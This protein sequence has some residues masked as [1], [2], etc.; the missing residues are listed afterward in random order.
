M[1]FSITIIQSYIQKLLS[2]S[3]LYIHSDV[4]GIQTPFGAYMSRIF[5]KT[6]SIDTMD[7]PDIFQ[8]CASDFPIKNKEHDDSKAQLGAGA[9]QIRPVIRFPSADC[10][11]FKSLEFCFFF[12]N[13]VHNTRQFLG[14]DI[15][16]NRFMT[17][18]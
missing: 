5:I 4:S 1:I 13:M 11:T 15:S 7:I 14:N 12:Q 3:A 16:G 10:H 6:A 2:V 18:A 8:A 17:F 9:C